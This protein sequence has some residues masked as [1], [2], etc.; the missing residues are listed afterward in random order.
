[1]VPPTSSTFGKVY[2]TGNVGSR[3]SG[4]LSSSSWKDGSDKVTKKILGCGT[5]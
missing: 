2:N 5:E 1:M 4:R 3:A